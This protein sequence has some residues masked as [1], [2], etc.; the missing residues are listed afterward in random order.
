MR[1]QVYYRAGILG[2]DF[3]RMTKEG[4]FPRDITSGALA[5]LS[6]QAARTA[7]ARK[8]YECGKITK[9]AQYAEVED[10]EALVRQHL[11]IS[12]RD[13]ILKCRFSI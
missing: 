7:L 5:E 11:N 2:R 9:E 13:F 3:R 8:A 10:L 1:L 4:I 12:L 6:L